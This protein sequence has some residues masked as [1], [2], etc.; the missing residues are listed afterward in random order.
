MP[1][2]N[3]AL[4]SATPN[5][6][7]QCKQTSAASVKQ[8]RPNFHFSK[9]TNLEYLTT[10]NCKCRGILTC[11]TSVYYHIKEISRSRS[12]TQSCLVL[13]PLARSPTSNCQSSVRRERPLPSL[14]F[15]TGRKAWRAKSVTHYSAMPSTGLA[16]LASTVKAESEACISNICWS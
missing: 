3:M 14:K 13:P 12:V 4:Y 8:I 11:I 6:N 7:R 15:T 16:H 1:C 5:I 2:P 10:F 9:D